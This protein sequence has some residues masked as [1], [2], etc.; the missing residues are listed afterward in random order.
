MRIQ[1]EGKW[2]VALGINNYRVDSE[3]ESAHPTQIQEG[4][5][6]K[7]ISIDED[8]LINYPTLWES[9]I[10][11]STTEMSK[12]GKLAIDRNQKFH[13]SRKYPFLG[14]CWY[15]KRVIIDEF[16]NQYIRLVIERTKFTKVYFDGQFVSE[17]FDT[18]IPQWH[19][20][21][22]NI[23]LGYHEIIV[24]VDN[25]LAAYDV[26][27][28]CLYNGHQYSEHTQ[29]NWNGILG[30]IYIET[31]PVISLGN[32]KLIKDQY[33]IVVEIDVFNREHGR[34]GFIE[35]EII[36]Y[37]NSIEME[38]VCGKNQISYSINWSEISEN[39]QL[40]DEFHPALYQ[41]KLSVISEGI[42]WDS[43][44][45]KIGFRDVEVK[46]KGIWINNQLIFLRGQIDCAIFPMTGAAPMRVREWKGIFEK[47]TVYGINHCRFHS[48][49]PPEAAFVA[50]DELG[51]YLQIELS[52]FATGFYEKESKQGC[53][54]ALN[55]FLYDQSMKIL[56]KYGNHP[57]FILFAVGNEMIGD[58]S[59]FN[60]L[61]KHLK[62][63]RPDKLYSQG[64]NNFL[65]TPVCC[66]EDDYW[67]VM[68]TTENK[69]N[70][71]ASFS[72]NDLPLGHIQT[73]EKQGTMMTYDLALQGSY[74]PLIS[75]EI[76]Q[77]QI[78]PDFDE[79]KEYTGVTYPTAL[80]ICRNQLKEKGLLDQADKFF[81]ASGML[82]VQC[83]KE[84]IEAIMRT[85]QMSG[86]QLLSL[87]DFPGQGTAL[88]GILKSSLESKGLI[89]PSEWKE[90]CN[91][92]TIF[93]KFAT[94][95]YW[96]GE[97]IKVRIGIFNYSKEDVQN[98][99]IRISLIN[100]GRIVDEISINKIHAKR[101]EVTEYQSIEF[102]TKHVDHA[103]RCDLLLEC[104]GMTNHYPIWI[105]PHITK[106][107]TSLF[108]IDQFDERVEQLLLEGNTVIVFDGHIENSIEAGYTSDFWCYP[109][110]REACERKN[111]KIAPGTMGLLID[112]WHPAL[113]EF[114]T[115]SYSSWQWQQ[116]VMSS[117]PVIL[118]EEK[119]D[120]QMIVQVIDNFDRNH[121]LGLIYERSYKSG[122]LIICAA[123]ILYKREI[124]EVNQLYYSLISYA[125]KLE[126]GL[127]N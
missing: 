36:D 49:C 23:Q 77:Y 56:L 85:P 67:V 75:H 8:V 127:N 124:P 44:Y 78:F 9:I 114:P 33:N 39:L 91:S 53:N 88:V 90:F 69:N 118:D 27:P 29:T 120:Y 73:A 43:K 57:S 21:S 62:Q 11:P 102:S 26:F 112:T 80:D 41:L 89:S 1:L 122:R 76:G 5:N 84:D 54:E 18:L 99:C 25:N 86:F 83:Y 17:S 61:L 64:A 60:R 66:K 38:L 16:K 110:F 40:W 52:C 24:E 31:I 65:E 106:E 10:L 92:K 6:C 55:E 32:I 125:N 74:I 104:G 100:E 105:Y 22:K 87:Q 37:K 35:L 107:A 12:K 101:G 2:E 47:Y 123:D 63:I 115:D 3:T 93:A 113:K 98:E 4:R 71:R 81:Q 51:I 48:W 68:R 111:I 79:I 13:L 95:T 103:M 119:E 14:K 20:L 82:A 108:V 94:Y 121:K 7:E 109:M 15:R 50:A 72:H 116:I 59:A 28:E 42:I 30:E 45:L 19:I 70:I 117:R 126:S 34:T 58:L 96:S 46:D 97:V